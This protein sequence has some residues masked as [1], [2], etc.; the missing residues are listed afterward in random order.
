MQSKLG[1]QLISIAFYAFFY[2]FLFL[3]IKYSKISCIRI[4]K[5]LINMKISH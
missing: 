1:N 2:A 4:N 3:F 5:M